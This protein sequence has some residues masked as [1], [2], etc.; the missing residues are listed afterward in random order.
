[1]SNA[2]FLYDLYNRYNSSFSPS[3]SHPASSR[4]TNYYKRYLLQRAMSVFDWVL[5]EIW[6]RKARNYFLYTL[7]CIG[8]IAIVETDAFGVIPQNCTLTGL[9]VFYQPQKV[10]VNNPRISQTIQPIIGKQCVLIKL[11]PDYGGVLDIVDYYA[12]QL[13]LLSEAVNVN[14]INSK[15]SFAFGASGKAISESFKKMY[16]DYASGKPAVFYDKSL[17]DPKTGELNFQFINKDVK[18]S[19]IITDLLNDIR[20]VMNHFDTHVGIKNSNINKRE[21]VLSGEVEANNVETKTLCELWLDSLKIGCE[22]TREMF[23]VDISVDWRE[24]TEP[25][26]EVEGGDNSVSVDN[27]NI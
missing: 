21:R 10:I 15:L 20:T 17:V 13:A 1:M 25:I 4:L 27:S 8:Y 5:P 16:D 12:E 18:S 6:E 23:G 24:T 2:P 3:E 9:D 7:Y 11:Q 22:E 19:Y 14:A 26:E